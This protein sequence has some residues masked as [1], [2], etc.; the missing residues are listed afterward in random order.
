[1]DNGGWLGQLNGP[2][3]SY[4]YLVDSGAR[5]FATFGARGHLDNIA[6]LLDLST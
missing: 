4:H 6:L 2:L 1:M 5:A 3:T